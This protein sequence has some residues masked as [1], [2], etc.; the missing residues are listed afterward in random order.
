MREKLLR[1][2]LF[3][4]IGCLG[5]SLHGQPAI[6]STFKTEPYVSFQPV[7][8]GFPLF[9]NGFVPP[10]LVSPD[11]HAGVHRVAVHLQDDLERVTG[12]RP[13]LFSGQTIDANLAI[14]IGTVG[15]SKL[16]DNLIS[17]GKINVDDVRGRWE[18]SLLQ[19]VDNPLPGVRQALVIVGSDKRGTIY[20]MFDLSAQIGVSPWYFWADVPINRQNQLFVKAGRY[21]LG[22]P[23]VR[24]RGIFINNEEP[25]LGNWVRQKF[26]GFNHTF[27][28]EVYELILRLKGN[29]LWPAMWG[30]AH[31]DDDP[32]N[33]VLA[34]EYGVVISYTHHEP[35]MRAHIEWARYGQGPWNYL[36]N[37]ETLHQFWRE[38]IARNHHRENFTIV[39]MRGDGDEPMSAQRNMEIM[40]GIV[41]DQ[42][43]IISEVTGRPANERPQ[44]WALYK[45]VQEYYDMGMRVPEDIMILY[46]NDN[47]GNVRRMP[48]AAERARPGGLGIYFHFDYVGGPRNHKWHNHSPLPHIW[49]QLKLSYAHG[50]DEL[51]LVNVGDI[52]PMEL[53][54]QFFL[55]L[56]WDPDRFGPEQLDQYLNAWARQKFGAEN[57]E[58][59]AGLL[60]RYTKFAGRRTAELLD[61]N[62]FSLTN[63]REFERVA[64]DYN[65]LEADARRVFEKIPAAAHDA[66]YQLVMFP[67]KN[68]A[69][70]YNLYHATA[71]NH[72][73]AKQQ[74]ARTNMMADSVQ[75]YFDNHGAMVDHFHT[76]FANGKWNHWKSQTVIGYTYWQQPPV[77][78]IPDTNR[79]TLQA[80]AVPGLYVE[81]QATEWS[82]EANQLPEFDAFNRQSRFIEIFNKGN[83][84]FKY[85]LTANQ[86]W[87]QFSAPRGTVTDQ[88]RIYVSINW[89][90]APVGTSTATVNV[91]AGN[92]QFDVNLSVWNPSASERANIRGFVE[93]NGYISM[94][95]VNYSKRNETS[96]VKWMRIPDMGRTKDG[97]VAQP[98][99]APIQ[100]PGQ[101]PSLEYEVYL[102]TPG[103][104]R[105]YA[106]FSPALNW[107]PDGSG[108]KYAMSFNN[109]TPQVVDVHKD[110]SLIY[111][112][113]L[114]EWESFVTNAINIKYT[115]HTISEPG[116]HT[117]R[118]H[119][120]S[121]GLVLQ[122]IVI[123]TGGL[124]ESKLGPEESYRVKK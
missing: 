80:G 47:W 110:L 37:R 12:N 79:I 5:L 101:G 109:E 106:Y 49:E 116:N 54:I 60:A 42:R 14:I 78:R 97:I 104:V 8:G 122:K 124:K 108:L 67:I 55:D 26:G 82:P 119:A 115:E 24:H 48:G 16:I 43:Q 15:Q 99:L 17:S 29:F 95:S 57:A 66:F 19:V 53:P 33:P 62:T 73:Y 118:F 112:G 123:D 94:E 50:I 111:G 83:R 21:N 100:V 39:G 86:P 105:V 22:E 90:I 34:D 98:Y 11:D 28:G 96:D 41:N 92:R 32:L 91:K 7:T 20:G 27:Y 2:S 121:P 114:R 13:V 85:R 6:T 88:Q 70:L 93:T 1:L 38:G 77:N 84:Q 63:Y 46:C 52:K 51:W 44:I 23:K 58:E 76:D 3:L 61:W 113:P 31:T 18:V 89:D 74:R 25:T 72:F 65:E 68:Y 30:K 45:E 56:A 120:V 4:V 40:Q 117:L 71:R 64:A 69:N 87:V 10:L 59:I 36:K 81:G 103:K 102:R 35:M 107:S 75:S 9:N